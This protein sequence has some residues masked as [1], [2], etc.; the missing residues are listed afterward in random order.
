MERRSVIELR[1]RFDF[2]KWEVSTAPANAGPTI[3]VTWSVQPPAVDAGIPAVIA[4]ALASA[5][6]AIGELLFGAD[7]SAS[8]T[9]E[10]LGTL[11]LQRGLRRTEVSLLRAVSG[12]QLLPAFSGGVLDW[13]M[14]AQWIVVTTSGGRSESQELL[15]HVYERG[16]LPAKWPSGV[17]MV[18]QA[19]VDGDGAACHC[20]DDGVA[21]RFVTA[22]KFEAASRAIE[23][24]EMEAEQ[25]T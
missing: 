5:L 3:L 10:A 4:G 11:S 2:R 18:V 22:L 6:V 14:G 9:T 20:A 8:E 19:A 12:E 15:K 16:Q 23:C 17:L 21:S 7:P 24:I 1:W 25:R 13:S